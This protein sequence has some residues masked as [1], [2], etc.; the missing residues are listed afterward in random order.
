MCDAGGSG[1]KHRL[2]VGTEVLGAHALEVA[3]ACVE[4]GLGRD[5]GGEA[6]LLVGAKARP[7]W[8]VMPV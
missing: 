2:R 7:G 3:D 5:E 8:L 4:V 1:P 6:P